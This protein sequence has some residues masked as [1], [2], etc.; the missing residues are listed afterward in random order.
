MVAM[1]IFT[2][3][4]SHGRSSSQERPGTQQRR[5]F[6]QCSP[7]LVRCPKQILSESG[8][9]K[10][11]LENVT[12]AMPQFPSEV[13]F[14]WMISSVAIQISSVNSLLLTSIGLR[15]GHTPQCQQEARRQVSES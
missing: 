2:G 15:Q 6:D 13:E 5:G 4:S 14:D 9:Q 3:G 10:H 7:Y 12:P 1:V 11:D 8:E